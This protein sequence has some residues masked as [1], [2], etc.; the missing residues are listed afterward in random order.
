MHDM[1]IISHNFISYET[2][3]QLKQRFYNFTRIR[4]KEYNIKQ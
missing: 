2:Q 4:A 1:K 3:I